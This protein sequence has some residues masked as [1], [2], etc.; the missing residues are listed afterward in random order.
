MQ[1]GI[2]SGIPPIDGV[3][4]LA[5]VPS[6]GGRPLLEVQGKSFFVSCLD[7]SY[8]CL[9]KKFAQRWYPYQARANEAPG[10][11]LKNGFLM[12]LRWTLRWVK[13]C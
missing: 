8:V 13:N 6:G 4:P 12:V 3:S 5:L 10:F 2:L 9:N 7:F 11:L 1:S